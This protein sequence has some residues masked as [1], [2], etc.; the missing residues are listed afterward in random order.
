MGDFAAILYEKLVSRQVEKQKIAI[1]NVIDETEWGAIIMTIYYKIHNI[2]F[3]NCKI[4][5]IDLVEITSI[6][7]ICL[8]V[9]VHISKE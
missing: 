9:T 4:S 1:S 7:L 8:I 6:F 3:L 2:S 5:A